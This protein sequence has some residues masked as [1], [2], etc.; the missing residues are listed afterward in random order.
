MAQP[1][2]RRRLFGMRRRPQ[3]V[4]QSGAAGRRPTPVAS[5]PP[6]LKARTSASPQPQPRSSTELLG[7]VRTSLQ[8]QGGVL[9]RQRQAVDELVDGIKVVAE[10]DHSQ[11]ATAGSCGRPRASPVGRPPRVPRELPCASRSPY[12]RRS[13]G[14]HWDALHRPEPAIADA[15]Q[16]IPQRLPA[17]PGARPRREETRQSA[18]CP[19]NARC[20]RLQRRTRGRRRRRT[21][22]ARQGALRRGAHG[23]PDARHRRL[24]GHP[25]DS[26]RATAARGDE[27][28]ALPV[29][30]ADVL[31]R[32]ALW[33]ARE[34]SSPMPAVSYTCRPHQSTSSTPVA[35][36]TPSS[37][38]SPQR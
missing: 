18:G 27:T 33:V 13:C 26:R 24:R 4:G 12:A 32:A 11:D 38:C 17:L 30:E 34:L 6:A 3:L 35:R 29:D 1:E 9:L 19:R 31:D 2:S 22:P 5:G 10:D 23:L 37:A 15:R 20:H 14:R 21:R 28:P 7:G 16:R 8:K 25:A 36:G